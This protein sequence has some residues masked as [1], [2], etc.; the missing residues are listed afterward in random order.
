MFLLVFF[1][2]L[3]EY[4]NMKATYN[5]PF[6]ITPSILNL[7]AE[8][9][10]TVGRISA[11]SMPL[12]L[13]KDN[14]IRSIHSSLAIE[15]NSLSLEQVSAIVEGKKIVGL[16]KEIEEVKNAYACYELISK[17]NPTSVQ[18]LLKA[19]ATMMSDLVKKSGEFRTSGVAVYKGDEVVHMAPPAPQVPKLIERLFDWLK[20][21]TIHPLIA[22]CVFHYEFE[23]IHHFSDGNGRIGRFWQNLILS[24]WNSVFAYIP[25]ETVIYDNQKEYYEV[26]NIADNTAD[27]TLFIEFLLKAIKKALQSFSINHS[28][29]IPEHDVRVKKLLKALS[30]KTLSTVE[31]MK[32]LKLKN[33]ANFMQNYLNPA[34][35][36]NAIVSTS[37]TLSNPNQK[38]RVS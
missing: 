16:K 37:S 36:A 30:N 23:F 6:S 38:Y 32:K 28:I 7:V 18:D 2:R 11:V 25:I 31:I 3:C 4:V 10:E 21:A 29:D 5:P 13:R 14:K 17:L 19:H 22:S 27:S 24:K 8:I 9:T 33:R 20:N 34:L 26:L 12:H 15:N 35:K 1:M